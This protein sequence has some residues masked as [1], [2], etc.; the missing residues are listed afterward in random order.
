MRLKTAIAAIAAITWISVCPLRLPAKPTRTLVRSTPRSLELRQPME[1]STHER[2]TRKAA[3]QS[4]AGV[5]S[6]KRGATHPLG[7]AERDASAAAQRPSRSTQLRTAAKA[8]PSSAK[9]IS[10]ASVRRVHAWEQARVAY[11]AHLAD[12]A[13]GGRT[14]SAYP[15]QPA[16]RTQAAAA[17]TT[18][19]ESAADRSEAIANLAAGL[20]YESRSMQQSSIEDE[21]LIPFLL[22]PLREPV[23]AYNRGRLIVPAP[24]RGSHEILLHQN[25]MADREGLDRVRDDADLLDLRRERKLVALPESEG[26]RVDGS[27]PEDRRYSRPWTAAFLTALARDYYANFHTSLQVDSAVRTVAVQQHLVRINGNAAPVEGDTASPHLTGQAVDIAKGGLSRMQI[28][29]MRAYLQPLIDLGVI[30]VEEEFKQA[31]FHIS[32]YRNYLP[33]GLPRFSVAETRQVVPE[34]VP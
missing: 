25:E 34:P 7:H 4:A 3:A 28:A 6:E 12:H 22:P 1:R 23:L 24:L 17:S 19:D 26:L 31:C 5:R 2:A 30:D 29:W 15:T 9:S 11:D 14:S 8:V 16:S 27:L 10:Q 20:R 13:A 33:A 18:G 21:A 32:V